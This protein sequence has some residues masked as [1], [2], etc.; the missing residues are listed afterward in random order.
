[1][2]MI[3]RKFPHL[4]E[5]K[6]SKHLIY[7]TDAVKL[8]P[9][10]EFITWLT[11]QRSIW[12]QMVATESLD[13]DGVN[14]YAQSF[15]GSSAGLQSKSCF[16]CGRVSH[17][18]SNCPDKDNKNKSKKQ[19]CGFPKVKKHWCALHLGKPDKKCYTTNCQELR[20][21]D[22]G[23]R[24]KLLKD[25]GDCMHCCQDHK[26]ADCPKSGRVCSGGKSNLHNS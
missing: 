20:K 11:T 12:E 13:D 16:G 2:S 9:F 22:P 10:E 8:K 7:Q 21:L 26:T 4:V 23:T 17:V 3:V 1:M 18:R 14:P 5:E 24:I 19:P 6:R 25:N 15:F